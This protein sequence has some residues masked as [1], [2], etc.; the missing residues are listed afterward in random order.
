M[1]KRSFF[2]GAPGA[3]ANSF[4]NLQ[5][6]HK[7]GPILEET[8]YYP[9][10]LTMAGISSKALGFGAP[11]NKHKFNG[12]EQNNDFD[13]NTYE[14]FYRNYDPQI[15]RWHSLDTKP[16]DRISLYAAMANNPVRFTDPLG[17]TAVYFRPDGSFWKFQDDGKKEFSGVF[18]QKSTTTS[19]YEKNG[20]QYEVHTYS[21]G[22]NF[23]FN[24]AAVD[25][26]AIKNGEITN[27]AMA[28]D[29]LVNNE[30]DK[31]GVNSADTKKGFSYA[32][33]NSTA[34]GKMDYGMQPNLL[35]N[36]FY[37]REGTAY[38]VADFGNYLWGRG[39]AQLEVDLPLATIGAHYNNFVNGRRGRDVTEKY[40][41]GP[42]TY[43]SPGLFDSKSDQRAIISG[44]MN[45]PKYPMLQQREYDKYKSILYTGH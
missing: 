37:L 43:G 2:I 3:D 26:Q 42:G 35:K 39:M 14:F 15:G 19:T 4:D 41:F 1:R 22:V 17:D 25:V 8:H 32:K 5:V 34:G 40:N 29:A 7:P 6:I 45:N 12:I 44:Y 18:F 21:D 9:F 28:T 38:N 13:L 16:V 31:S 30:M 33:E 20:V 23:Q 10:G 27:I 24:D 11:E 36:T